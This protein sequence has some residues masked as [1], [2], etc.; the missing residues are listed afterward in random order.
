MS[1]RAERRRRQAERV[2]MVLD[3]VDGGY[4]DNRSSEKKRKVLRPHQHAWLNIQSTFFSSNA[5]THLTTA[6]RVPYSLFTK[7]ARELPEHNSFWRQKADCTGRV[8]VSTE[9]KILV[10]LKILGHGQAAASVE[11][12]FQMGERLVL[13][14]VDIFTKDVIELYDESAITSHLR[15]SDK[16]SESL[17]KNKV[18]HG[19]DGYAG[20]LDCVHVYWHMYPMSIQGSHK[21][22]F[23]HPTFNNEAICDSSLRFTHFYA[24]APGCLNDINVLRQGSFMTTLCQGLLPRPRYHL[25]GSEFNF[26]F[27]F[28]DGIYPPW[29]VLMKAP[30]LAVDEGTK[31][32]IERQESIRKD[33]ERA[34][35]ILKCR[36]KILKNGLMYKKRSKCVSVIK[37]CAILHNMI[38]DHQDLDPLKA[39]E[40]DGLEI[41]D[42]NPEEMESS[43][44][45]QTQEEDEDSSNSGSEAEVESE[46]FWFLSTEEH[47][48]LREAVVRF[49]S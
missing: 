6:F 34:F 24:G 37:T 33:I 20:A 48:R 41:E 45:K 22:R 40:R 28:V 10:A 49:Y 35:G 26:P 2:M 8:G 14:T 23:K 43:T 11:A 38:I 25:G 12:E 17:R 29:S 19:L 15:D 31:K 7:L 9:M 13:N 5:T 39:L 4:D 21:G 30:T 47:V 3:V 18:K 1:D 27:F 16:L 46:R 44:R 42:P 32:F 36:M